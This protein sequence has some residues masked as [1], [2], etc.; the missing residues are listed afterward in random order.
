[1]IGPYGNH[2]S[3]SF[4]RDILNS[5]KNLDSVFS[6]HVPYTHL[7]PSDTPL[8]SSDTPFAS[9]DTPLAPSDFLLARWPWC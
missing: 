6:Y 9:S 2:T 4:S 1:M 5:V 7:A 3:S 8:A